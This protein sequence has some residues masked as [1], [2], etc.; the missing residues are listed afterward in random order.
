MSNATEKLTAIGVDMV[1]IAKVLQDDSSAFLTDTPIPFAPVAEISGAPKIN[2][3]TLYYDD[4]PAEDL[5]AEGVT[6]RKVK[7]SALNP[8]MEALVTGEKF[9]PTT[10]QVWD[11]AA[12]ASSPFFAFGY[13]SQKSNGHYRYVWYLK[14]RFQKP[15]YD[16]ETLADKATAKPVEITYNAQKTVH[17]FDQG[18]RTDGVKR[19]W[20][21][22]D[23]D[24]A[25]VD[26]WFAAVQTPETSSPSALTCTPTPADGATG[27]LVSANIVLTFNNRVRSGN[28]GIMIAKADGTAVAAAYSWNAAGKVLTI[29]PSSNL[30][31][32]GDYIVTLSGVTDIYGQTLANTAYNFT[33][34]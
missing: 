22:E 20:V 24:N 27:V 14:G 11:S 33:T 5:L 28:A 17:K 7:I 23:T 12:P 6:E 16:H 8:E 3:E 32:S 30:G 25:D 31:A 1:Y 2:H 18:T 15:G 4:M 10:G 9:D 21:D 29:D 26:T 19:V 34:A 13:R